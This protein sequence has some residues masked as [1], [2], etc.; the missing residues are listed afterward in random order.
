VKGR[1]SMIA[2]DAKI[3]ISKTVD[4]ILYSGKEQQTITFDRRKSWSNKKYVDQA[5][6]QTGMEPSWDFGYSWEYL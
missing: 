2:T 5:L 1:N 4:V 3:L 6:K